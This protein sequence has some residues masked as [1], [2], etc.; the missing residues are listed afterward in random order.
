M[1]AQSL[2]TTLHRQGFTLTPLP[3]GKLEI[4]PASKLTPALREELKECKAAVLP[5]VEAMTWLRSK[6]TT[7]QHIALLI[8]EWVEGL[9]APTDHDVDALMQAR[10]TLDVEAYVGE[11]DRLWWRLPQETVQ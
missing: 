4:R 2:L 10:W 3:D 7:P 9:D 6:L 8:S 1:H 5:L 11:D